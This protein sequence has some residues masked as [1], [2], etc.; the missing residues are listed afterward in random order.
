MWTET[1]QINYDLIS[2]KLED[3]EVR[4]IMKD[5]NP[6]EDKKIVFFGL[7]MKL[8]V[9]VENLPLWESP[10]CVFLVSSNMNIEHPNVF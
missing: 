7:G 9:N 8:D 1:Q 2:R 4:R 3:L 5:V 10:G 6:H